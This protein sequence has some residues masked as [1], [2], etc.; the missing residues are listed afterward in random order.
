MHHAQQATTAPLVVRLPSYVQQA[1]I[2]LFQATSLRR[3][4]VGPVAQQ[5][6]RVHKDI[7]VLQ[8]ARRL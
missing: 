5:E 7:T 4:Q 6:Q 1:T 2:V 3:A 8:E